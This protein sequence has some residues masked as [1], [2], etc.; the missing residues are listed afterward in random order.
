MS[1]FGRKKKKFRG[2]DEKSEPEKKVVVP[3]K[4]QAPD[5]EEDEEEE[6]EEEGDLSKYKLDVRL[7]AG[8]FK[9]KIKHFVQ[10]KILYNDCVI[11][12]TSSQ[13]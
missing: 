11:T 1:Q 2:K 5:D 3:I 4:V 13:G 7:V 10:I 6:D 8:S 12:N 9:F